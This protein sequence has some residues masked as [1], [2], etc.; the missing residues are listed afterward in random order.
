VFIIHGRNGSARVAV[1]H[2]LKALKLEPLDFDELAADMGTE[3]VGNIVL[4]GL[5][6][7]KG[8]VVLFTPDEFAA[9]LPAFRGG[10]DPETEIKRW[11]SR[12]NVI[13]EAGIA[14]GVARERSVLVTLGPE[15]S[16]FSDVAGIHILRLANS[17]ESRG[18]FRQ[19]LIGTGCDV[20]QRTDAWTDAAKSGDFEKCVL[21]DAA[22]RD[23]FGSG[24][25][26]AA[27][28]AS[29][30]SDDEALSLVTVWLR[31]RP[32]QSVSLTYAQVNTELPIP[33]PVETLQRVF[34]AAAASTGWAVAVHQSIVALTYHPP[35]PVVR[36]SSRG[37]GDF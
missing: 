1:E 5:R 21:T 7:A 15:V 28:P 33:V 35:M 8:I 16:L 27:A 11:Q 32:A 9:L 10:H 14:F 23:P 25:A 2:F 19:K 6:R 29:K 36:D 20:D 22:V 3:F 31:R 26:V 4:E 34:Q 12:P 37:M 24:P 13:F 18:K 17:V 30:V